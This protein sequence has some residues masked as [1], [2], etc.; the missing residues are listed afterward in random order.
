MERSSTNSSVSSLSDEADQVEATNG[1]MPQIRSR[2]YQLEMLEKSLKENIIVA[3]S[4]TE[5][6]SSSKL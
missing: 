6:S 1:D 3:V 4:L 2:S 5:P